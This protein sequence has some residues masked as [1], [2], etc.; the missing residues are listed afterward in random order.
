MSSKVVGLE[1]RVNL[2]T[3]SLGQQS[4]KGHPMRFTQSQVD[5]Y[6][7]RRGDARPQEA[8]PDARDSKIDLSTRPTL[9]VVAGGEALAV[10]HAVKA[11]GGHVS[12]MIHGKKNGQWHL[13]IV[14]TEPLKQT[15]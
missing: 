13:S 11:R 4:S 12:G 10:M 7:A 6:N 9:L 5:A 8:M 15:L 1:S 14:W 2:E 3:I